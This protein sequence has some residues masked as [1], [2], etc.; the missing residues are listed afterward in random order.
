MENNYYYLPTHLAFINSVRWLD[1]WDILY[2]LA[3]QNYNSVVDTPCVTFSLTSTQFTRLLYGLPSVAKPDSADLATGRKTLSQLATLAHSYQLLQKVEDVNDLTFNTMGATAEHRLELPLCRLPKSPPLVAKP[4]SYIENGWIAGVGSGYY[5]RHLLNFYLLQPELAGNPLSDRDLAQKLSVC[6]QQ[7]AQHLPP[8]FKYRPK[9]SSG[10]L[11]TLQRRL[12]EARPSLQ[13]RGLLDSAKCWQ[14]VTLQTR[15]VRPPQSVLVT[16]ADA[17]KE[18]TKQLAEYTHK[19]RIR[20]DRLNLLWKTG[21]LEATEIKIAWQTLP[22]FYEQSDFEQLL[23]TLRQ[24]TAVTG[25]GRKLSWH[26][27]DRTA[28]ALRS[29]HGQH[30]QLGASSST[31]PAIKLRSVDCRRNNLMPAELKAEPKLYPLRPHLD[32]FLADPRRLNRVRLEVWA[33]VA[34]WHFYST[35]PF[36]K[37]PAPIGLKLK[38]LDANGQTIFADEVHPIEPTKPTT[39]WKIALDEAFIKNWWRN[40]DFSA[41]QAGQEADRKNLFYLEIG[42]TDAATDTLTEINSGWLNISMRLS[43]KPRNH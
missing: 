2:Y 1:F 37:R 31:R 43:F 27:I 28:R 21:L 13:L 19:D 9:F 10:Q 5:E 33:K 35:L 4:C 24:R 22:A 7:A 34:N 18:V 15:F 40:Q 8:T 39:V 42:R 26:E 36:E 30:N 3:Y 20:G 41:L 38:L 25:A 16:M 32:A 23:N 6:Y 17:D 12:G 11:P 29:Q 14:G